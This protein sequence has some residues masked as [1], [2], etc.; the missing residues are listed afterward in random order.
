MR[1]GYTIIYVASVAHTL[2]FYETAFGFKTRFLHDSGEYGELE[3]GSTTLAFASLELAEANFHGACAPV[4]PDALP[5][6]I[7]LAFVT[8]DVAQSYQ[9]A[10]DAGA[11]PVHPPVEKPWG[12][13]IAYVRSLEGTLI[14]LCTPVGG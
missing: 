4:K 1:F 5:P 10:V 2:A 13:T 12:Q 11:T 9:T 8:E 7:E 3:T 14:E 6:G